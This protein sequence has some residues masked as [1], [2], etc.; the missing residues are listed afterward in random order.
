MSVRGA[1]EEDL[2][3]P[4]RGR[5]SRLAATVL[6]GDSGLV[7]GGDDRDMGTGSPDADAVVEASG[8][9]VDCDAGA[10]ASSAAET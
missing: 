1:A 2:R 3:C 5:S 9:G 10:A 6:D 7:E 8:G 4:S